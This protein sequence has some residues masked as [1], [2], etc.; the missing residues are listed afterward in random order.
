MRGAF[1]NLSTRNFAVIGPV[2]VV[3]GS[4]AAHGAAFSWLSALSELGGVIMTNSTAP[5]L[6]SLQAN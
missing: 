6:V 4:S 5:V 2:V 3:G 1:A